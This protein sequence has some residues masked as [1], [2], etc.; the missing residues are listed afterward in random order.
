MYILD[1]QLPQGNALALASGLEA[2]TWT[3]RFT[4]SARGGAERLWFHARV[5]N[6]GGR[7]GDP[8]R[9]VLEEV[10]QLLGGGAAHPFR[11]VWCADGGAW[12]RLEAG[13]ETRHPDG[14]REIAWTVPAPA[15]EGRL[16]VC[17][18]Y[19]EDELRATVAAGGDYWSCARIGTSAGDRPLLR[20]ANA[21]GTA[22]DQRPGIYCTARNHSGET[23]GSWALDGFLRHLAE[24]ATDDVLVWCVP[25]VD[26][27]GVDR[28]DYGKDHWPR[29]VN[30][31]WTGC[32]SYRHEVAQVQRDVRR[33]AERCRPLLS[34][35]WHA[36]GMRDPNP[37]VHDE[38]TA[39]E[40]LTDAMAAAFG[41]A[42]EG[43][44]HNASYAPKL[45]RELGMDGTVPNCSTWFRR[46][47][48]IRGITMEVPYMLVGERPLLAADYH[49]LG[50]RL[51]DVCLSWVRE[52]AAVEA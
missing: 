51:A 50:A 8:L 25:F 3:L 47:F 30:R 21:A 24:Q 28:G 38:D 27:D 29:D 12:S 23:P 49:E 19:G 22:G 4:P 44:R 7:A 37:H 43:F 26:R 39:R 16:A 36:P 32:Q 45:F 48:G 11:P 17:L 6:R 1:D 41:I 18:P 46:T 31:A 33:W 13:I 5:C 2:G 15:T 9:L 14:R 20:L 40:P 52:H 35:D 34:L 10:D 42:P